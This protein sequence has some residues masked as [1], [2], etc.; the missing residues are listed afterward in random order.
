MEFALIVP[1][2]MLILFGM[3]TTGFAYNDHLSISN[4]VREGSRF[5]IAL[6]YTQTGWATSVR[7]RVKDV[8]FNDGSTLTNAQICVKIVTNTGTPGSPVIGNPAGS[9]GNW[10]GS[11]CDTEPANPSNMAT[12]SCAVKVWVEKPAN[13]DLI[14]APTMNFHIKAKSVA[15]YGRTVGGAGGCVAL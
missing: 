8:Y 10:A 12:G 1:F 2:L 7:D 4:A 13:I 15:Y 3:V 6:D 9:T 14:I 5:G 11:D